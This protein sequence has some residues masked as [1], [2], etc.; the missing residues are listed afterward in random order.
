MI[1]A[2]LDGISGVSAWAFRLRD[3]LA[4]HPR[5]RIVLVNCRETG[6]RVGRFDETATTLEAMA[7][8][9]RAHGP[10]IVIPNFVWPI[11]DVCAGLINEG[12]S[13]RCVGYCRADSE[14][15]YYQPLEWYA[16]L[17]SQF[18][19]VSPECASTLA[20]R[21]PERARDITTLPTGVVVPPTLARDY[22]TAPIRL[23]YGGRIVQAQK[24]V[25][26][27]V[28][29]V[30][31]LLAR[32]VDFTFDIA[33][34]GRQLA[35]LKSAMAALDHGGRV[36][37]LGKVAPSDMESLWR[38]NDVFIQTS[39]FEGTSNSMLEAMAQGL[40]PV[41]TRTASGIAGVVEEG[42]NGVLVAVG[43]MDAMAEAIAALAS[44]PERLAGLGRAAHATVQRYSMAAHA[45]RFVDVLDRVWAGEPRAWPEER[46][47]RL[48]PSFEGL[49]L[50][51]E[52]P[53]VPPDCLRDDT[54]VLVAAADENFVMPLA[55]MVTSALCNLA[56]DRRLLLYVMDGGIAPGSR[57]RLLESWGSQRIF[58][59]WLQ[60]DLGLLGDL[61][62]TGHVNA[63]T[64]A[65]LLM[66]RLVPDRHDRVIYLDCDLIVLGDL[67]EL[68]DVPLGDRALL[69]A[70]DMTAPWMDSAVALE[71]FAAC[72]PY[73]SAATA[74][75]NYEALGIAPKTPYFNAGVMV[76]NLAR[77]RADDV[78]GRVLRYLRDHATFVRWWDQDGL[79]AVLHDQWGALDPR[80]NQ[81]PHIYRYPTQAESPFDAAT[82]DAIV[83]DPKVVHFSARS[84]P[85]HGDN[86]HPRRDLYF[87]WLD[88]TAWAGWR[89][90]APLT[91]A[92][93]GDFADWRDGAPEGWTIPAGA[94]LT[95]GRA[96]RSG[97]QVVRIA[98][99]EGEAS[100]GLEQR[101]A[102]I[103]MGGGRLSVSLDA[104]CA[105]REVLALN[106]HV[107][108][109]GK[110]RTWSAVHPGHGA[111]AVLRH[112]IDLPPGPAPGRIQCNI[113][114][115]A[116]ATQ[117]AEVEN[118]RAVYFL[119]QVEKPVDMAVPRTVDLRRPRRRGWWARFFPGTRPSVVQEVRAMG[120]PM[121]SVI[122]S[123]YNGAEFL[124]AALRSVATQSWR[125][126][127]FI[128][129]DDGS[130]DDSVAIIKRV[131]GEF[132]DVIRPVFKAANEGQAAGF[133]EGFSTARGDLVCFV[134]S[135]DLWFPDKLKHLAA[136]AEAEPGCAI[137][138]HNLFKLV[139]GEVTGERFRDV[140][141]SGDLLAYTRRTRYFPFF[142][143][144]SG[145]AISRAALE[146]VMPIPP[147]FRVCA[148]GYLTRTT[149]CFGTIQ[150]TNECWGAYRVHGGNH[151]FENPDHDS[152]AYTN[153]LLI[154][155]LNRFYEANGIDLRFEVK[156]GKS[157]PG[158][159]LAP[160]VKATNR[161]LVDRVLDSS[162]R[163]LLRE[164]KRRLKP[165]D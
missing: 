129:V 161:R 118:F 48:S 59:R 82:F 162:I 22:Q 116:A 89:P 141:Q 32:G 12:V 31:A 47:G 51:G 15:E 144:T 19:A 110:R 39:D 126:F 97:G 13:L 27:F 17:I 65:R 139:N 152:F 92:E 135:D 99:S 131:A 16:P 160:R 125:D 132:P 143:P 117:P 76:V 88:R 6:N 114:L 69:A 119:P 109:A 7:A 45:A 105:E 164:V 165:G 86:T 56:E 91:L 146:S 140:V 44:N 50:P 158:H 95:P 115:R 60:P 28:P 52:G 77:W 112:E 154:P 124:E 8:L 106:L 138:Q 1:I 80:W 55:A 107:T 35:E 90:V 142:V 71:N 57:A 53:T 93:N 159:G 75:V 123:N 120:S 73:L 21:L 20:A 43:E 108:A 29:L 30:A 49:D 10:A 74:L 151:V 61:K 122:L 62:I 101:L 100:S 72:A 145:L 81:I 96:G 63:L 127:E 79:N 9:L 25:L 102:A 78:A 70:Q 24:R 121:I 133:N 113:V 128:V 54:I 87:A 130:T 46:R 85:W 94:R 157:A 23:I 83:N 33:G 38:R 104:C 14:G 150:S 136:M 37:F 34:Q 42:V 68:W 163:E 156:A 58:V 147:V 64:Y 41:V 103:P 153:G 26:D 111:W 84:K 98:P 5:Y 40:V 2:G 149:M 18:I 148:D 36:R 155:T 137:Y 11:F 134:D 66:P 3:A 4:G 67:A